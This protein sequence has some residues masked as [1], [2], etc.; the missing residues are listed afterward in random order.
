MNIEQVNENTA[1]SIVSSEVELKVSSK[2]TL[3]NREKITKWLT[4]I[5]DK[6]ALCYWVNYK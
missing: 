2:K 1:E 6:L 4:I 3:V 5:S